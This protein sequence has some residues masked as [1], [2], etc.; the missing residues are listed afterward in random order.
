MRAL[1]GALELWLHLPLNL[2]A[3]GPIRVSPLS[4]EPEEPVTPIDIAGAIGQPG[5]NVK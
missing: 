2:R 3:L 4:I 1:A 5:N